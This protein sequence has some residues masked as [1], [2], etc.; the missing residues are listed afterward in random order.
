LKHSPLIAVNISSEIESVYQRALLL[1]QRATESPVQAELVEAAIQELFFVLEELQASQLELHRQNQE[2]IA[3]R[4]SV[5]IERQRYQALFELAPDGYLVTDRQG[6]ICDANRAA[7]LMFAISQEYLVNKP[8]TL[9][10]HESDRLQ[11]QTQLLTLHPPQDWIVSL[12]VYNGEARS[13]AI[14]VA[15]IQGN[16]GEDS[17]LLWLLRPIEKSLPADPTVA[18]P[19]NSFNSL[20]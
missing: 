20:N 9:L 3:T 7:A 8:L 11:F 6:I 17:A 13:V 18:R 10:I 19:K 16:P 4:W 5:E 14:T 1:R 2:L 12:N 15:H